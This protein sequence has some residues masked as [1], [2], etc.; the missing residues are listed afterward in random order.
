[1]R[2]VLQEDGS[3]GGLQEDG[4][5]GGEA[6]RRAVAGSLENQW[7]GGGES[8]A[9]NGRV[10]NQTGHGTCVCSSSWEG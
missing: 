4:S 9:P 1:M 8:V 2:A 10:L 3:G 6:R 5:G 7:S